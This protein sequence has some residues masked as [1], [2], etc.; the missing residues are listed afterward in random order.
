MLDSKA[1][2]HR[3]RYESI[4]LPLLYALQDPLVKPQALRLVSSRKFPIENLQRL[5][6]MTESAGGMTFA[7]KLVA[8]TVKDAKVCIATIEDETVH[9]ALCKLAET[10]LIR[11]MEWKH[12]L[13]KT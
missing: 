8:Q 5:L 10:A 7:A 3:I 4:P 13:D 9:K 2:K 1:L 12:L 6:L 11:P